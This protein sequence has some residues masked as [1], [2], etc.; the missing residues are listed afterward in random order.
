MEAHDPYA[1]LP[2]LVAKLQD[3]LQALENGQLSATD[4]THLT[5]TAREVYERLLVLRYK[6]F[7]AVAKNDDG[8]SGFRINTAPDHLKTDDGQTSLI[9]AIEEIQQEEVPLAPTL[10]AETEVQA[11]IPVA[12]PVAEPEPTPEPIPL[13]EPEPESEPEPA[14][15][16]VVIPEAPAPAEDIAAAPVP[17]PEAELDINQVASAAEG[18]DQES[19]AERLERAP[20]EQLQGNISLNQKFLMIG[21]LFDGDSAQYEQ[22]ISAID[23]AGNNNAAHSLISE[24]KAEPGQALELI[25]DLVERRYPSA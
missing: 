10:F 23:A 19:I 17:L 25:Q 9:D 5:D 12:P 4:L 2:D 11:P 3:K 22:T 6:A 20:L 21:E 13:P 24:L 1:Q 14:P 8:N 15:I 7:E 16:A 18:A